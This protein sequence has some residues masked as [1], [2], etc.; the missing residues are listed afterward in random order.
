MWGPL[1]HGRFRIIISM[2]NRWVIPPFVSLWMRKAALACLLHNKQATG[3]PD[4]PSK[5]GVVLPLTCT[6]SEWW[7]VVTVRNTIIINN[8]S[9][10]VLLCIIMQW[11]LLVTVQENYRAWWPVIKSTYIY[12]FFVCLCI[13]TTSRTRWRLVAVLYWITNRGDDEWDEFV[14]VRNLRNLFIFLPCV[15]TAQKLLYVVVLL[16]RGGQ[17][18]YR[19][20]FNV[21]YHHRGSFLVNAGYDAKNNNNNM[22][23]R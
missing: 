11:G 12:Y 8:G 22:K 23:N 20:K 19:P 2:L 7:L 16:C 1:A 14:S 17:L 4:A 13:I 10:A 6:Y 5:V 9:T 18:L 15:V 3:G 21:L